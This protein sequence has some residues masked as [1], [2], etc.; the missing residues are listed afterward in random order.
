MC[1]I[2]ESWIEVNI[3][4][5]LNILNIPYDKPTNPL[6]AIDVF[7]HFDFDDY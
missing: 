6:Q 4:V 3:N 7:I 1:W 5:D 2:C